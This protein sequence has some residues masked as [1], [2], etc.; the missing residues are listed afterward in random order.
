M[1]RLDLIS[2][3][4]TPRTTTLLI[5]V[6]IAATALIEWQMG[7][8]LF[9]KCG[10]V[11]VWSGDIWSNQNSQQFAD[12]YSFTHVLHG[13]VFYF[14]IH[15]AAGR[16]ASMLGKLVIAVCLESGWEILENSSFIIDRYRAVTISLDY[17]GDSILNSVSDIFA[18]MLGFLI[19]NR[20]PWKITLVGAIAVDVFLLFWI[21]DSLAL[22]VLMLI[23]PIESIKNW[24]MG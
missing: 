16:H 15:V 24:Q 8:L 2:K 7:R 12:P 23:Y 21:K 3:F 18:M 4:L 22:N 1:N 6:I 20:L 9:C 17:Y 11:S 13:V 5:F 19:A 10:V 14:L